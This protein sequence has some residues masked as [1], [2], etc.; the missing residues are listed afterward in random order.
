MKGSANS[1]CA[2][3]A[4]ISSHRQKDGAS[5]EIQEKEMLEYAAATK[6]R[7]K[8]VFRVVESAKDSDDRR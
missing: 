1:K 5:H 4:R 7:V 3:F 2:I 8:R 6:L